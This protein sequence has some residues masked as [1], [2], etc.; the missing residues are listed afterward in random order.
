MTFRTLRLAAAAASIV[1][2]FSTTAGKAGLPSP[3]P[4]T[5]GARLPSPGPCTTGAG[6]PALQDV[7][8]VGAKSPDRTIVPVNQVVTPIGIQINLPGLRPQALALSPDGKLLAVAGK[9]PEI[10]I[11]H[12]STGAVRQRV[13]LPAEKQ[14]EQQPETSSPMILDPDE[15]GQLSYTG[16]I[17]APDG[18]RIYMSNVDGSIKVFA[19]AADGEVAPS[20]TI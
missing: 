5:T 18:G 1:L 2:L 14:G 13:V 11:L 7:E 8:T 20:H 12:P 10:V 15:E 6:L 9:T 16:L 17:F 4:C 3:G 19:V